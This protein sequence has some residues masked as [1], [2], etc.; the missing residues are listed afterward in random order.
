MREKGI[1][2]WLS[3][4]FE[5]MIHPIDRTDTWKRQ[6]TY[7]LFTALLIVFLWFVSAVAEYQLTGRNFNFNK[8]GTLNLFL[9]SVR[10]VA[11]YFVFVIANWAVTT[12]QEGKGTFTQI[13]VFT[14]YSMLPMVLCSFLATLLSHWMV[15]DEAIFRSWVIWLGILWSGVI[16]LT[17]LM[18][19]HQ[20]SFSKTI[21]SF[22]LTAFAMLVI[23]YLLILFFSLIQQMVAFATTAYN[24]LYFRYA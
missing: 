10:T 15:Q 11:V 17:S 20:Y 19:L 14:G 5:L 3:Q 13:L 12:L 9:V 7:S 23:V 21:L 8:P 2:K 22:L 16:L 18:T 1:K 4:P 24:E 6:H